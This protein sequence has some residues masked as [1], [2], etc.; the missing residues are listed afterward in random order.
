MYMALRCLLKP[1]RLVE[2]AKN[3]TVLAGLATSEALPPASI[4]LNALIAPFQA[5]PISDLLNAKSVTTFD[6]SIASTTSV[7]IGPFEFG[8]LYIYSLYVKKDHN[9]NREEFAASNLVG[10]LVPNSSIK[11]LLQGNS[12]D[13]VTCQFDI[14]ASEIKVAST[15][16]GADAT[17]VGGTAFV[18]K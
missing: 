6:G 2:F 8:I 14:T 11:F 12:H 13:Y 7:S 9:S 4:K 10:F 15:I 18:L 16:S 3:L 1:V 5:I 17:Y